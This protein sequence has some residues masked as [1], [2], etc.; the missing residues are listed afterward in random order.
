M[1][2]F[3][4]IEARSSDPLMPLSMFR[5]RT[6]HRQRGGGAVGRRD[7]R[8]VLRVGAL[9][10]AR[11]GYDAMQVGLAFLPG[12]LIMAVASLGLSAAGDALRHPRAAGLGL[13]LAALGLALFARAHRRQLH[14][15]RA[16]R[17]GAAGLGA[18]VAFNPMLLAAMSDVEPSRSGL[19][20]GLVNTAF[21]MGGA[22]GLAALASLAAARSAG[23]AAAGAAPQA[24]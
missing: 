16:A 8:V 21:M 10:A 14:A 11:V 9:H 19:A 22:L 13:A 1:A 7:V 15:R 2:L 3:L 6:G 12:N 17:D 4:A 18:G 20:S 5:L 23:L 24:R